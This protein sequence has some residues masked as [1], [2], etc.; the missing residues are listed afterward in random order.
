MFMNSLNLRDSGAFGQVPDPDAEASSFVN[1]L[2]ST[3]ASKVRFPLQPKRRISQE[4]VEY[5][6]G[7]TMERMNS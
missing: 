3:K 4:A 6:R 1:H 2:F 5:V 7:P